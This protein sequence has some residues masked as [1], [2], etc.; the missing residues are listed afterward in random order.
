M[1]SNMQPTAIKIGLAA[2]LFDTLSRPNFGD[3]PLELF[4]KAGL[5]WTR[6]GADGGQVAPDVVADFDALY[7]GGARVTE[8]SLAR[9]TGRLRVVA[10]HGV[11]Y[12]TVDTDA[13]SKRGILLTNTP[14]A[15][16]HPVASMALTFILSLALRLPLK[17][18]LPREGRWHERGDYT[19]MGLP[20][21]RLGIV[22]L[23]GIA[24]EL[25]RVI[26]PFGMHIIGAD[27][28]VTQD[29]LVGTGI[30]RLP[31]DAV[32]TQ[33]D[34]VVI[35]CVLND[36]T[37]HLINAR[38]LALMKPTAYFINVARG[39]IVDETALIG[40]LRAGKLAGAALDVFE[41]EP[42]DMANPL[43]SMENVISTPHSLCW[44][45]GFADGVARSAIKSVIDVAQGRLPEHIVNRD[46]LSH[47]RLK[48]LATSRQCT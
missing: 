23:G 43:L 21:R 36:S 6:L 2:D 47:S 30:E 15:I 9:D 14:I 34:F 42:V 24:R 44:T 27:P 12:D 39:P 45:D 8:A 11:G 41:Q 22:G 18:R 32:M 46:A 31:L 40:A 1:A 35:A 29:Q 17:S 38:L 16:R 4:D 33:S 3:A 10:R 20:G 28:Y 48:W 26:Q 7:I 37:H 5:Q 13:L 19:G 25:A